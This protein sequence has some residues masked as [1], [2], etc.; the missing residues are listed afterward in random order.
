MHYI[1]AYFLFSPYTFDLMNETEIH[2]GDTGYSY[3]TKVL[4]I[5][6]RGRDHLFIANVS[7]HRSQLKLGVEYPELRR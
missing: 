4:L 5:T 1:F 7:E 6:R 2:I 3:F